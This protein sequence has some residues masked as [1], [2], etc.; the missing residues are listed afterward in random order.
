VIVRPL[1]GLA[2]LCAG[3]STVRAQVEVTC[4]SVAGERRHCPADTS[5]GV[6]LA[7]STGS[8]PCLLGKTWGYDDSGVWVEDGCGGEFLVGQAA[9]AAA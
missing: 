5:A 3:A 6:V 9:T 2:L 7:R 1:L 4:T 8:A